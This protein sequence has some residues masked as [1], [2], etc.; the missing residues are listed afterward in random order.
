MFIFNQK[1]TAIHTSHFFT[2]PEN[3]VISILKLIDNQ[4]IGLLWNEVVY[5]GQ[6]IWL[7]NYGSSNRVHRSTVMTQSNCVVTVNR[8]SRWCWPGNAIKINEFRHTCH[9]YTIPNLNLHFKASATPLFF[10]KSILL[11]IGHVL[12]NINLLVNKIINITNTL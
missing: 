1:Q 8:T 10:F 12:I 5:T 9:L 3:F 4:Q 6:D 7:R 2:W 11:Q